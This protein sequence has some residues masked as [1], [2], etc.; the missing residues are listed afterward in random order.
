SGELDAK[1]QG[2]GRASLVEAMR[3]VLTDEKL[4]DSMRAELMMLPSETYLF[5]QMAIGERLA[6]PGAIHT[7]RE[8][9]KAALGA[10]L[11]SELH[12]IY[13]R[14]Q[15]VTFDDPAGRGARKIKTQV[16]VLAAA[17]DPAK[18]AEL[19]AYQYDRA[20]NMTDRQ[21]ALMVLCGLDSPERSERLKTFFDRYDSN[22][23]VIDKWF[24]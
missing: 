5:E 24:T 19:A 14:L 16:L 21:G 9:L 7:E 10:E 8:A 18:A 23:L 17:S 3:A 20:D 13:D 6:D 4:D 15:N 2:V 12:E 11:A 22:E 1:A